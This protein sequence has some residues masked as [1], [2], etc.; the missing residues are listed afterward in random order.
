MLAPRSQ[1]CIRIAHRLYA[2]ILDRIE[3]VDHE[4]F[5]HRASV[6]LQRKVAVAAREVVRRPRPVPPVS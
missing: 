1:A 6:P 4:V 5:T 2:E 3:A